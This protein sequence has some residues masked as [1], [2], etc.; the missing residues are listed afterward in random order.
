MLAYM[1]SPVRGKFRRISYS[2]GLSIGL[3]I[4]QIPS[5]AAQQTPSYYQN[6]SPLQLRAGRRGALVGGM[7]R[8]QDKPSKQLRPGRHSRFRVI[9]VLTATFRNPEPVAA[10]QLRQQIR[11][12]LY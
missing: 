2:I 3:A 10:P 5:A 1:S 4:A 9:K 6:S 11:Q 7:R 8:K 12:T